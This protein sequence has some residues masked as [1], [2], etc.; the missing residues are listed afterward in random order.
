M[1]ETLY[2][3]TN[4]ASSRPQAL[5]IPYRTMMRRALPDRIESETDLDLLMTEPSDGLV[6]LFSRMSGTLAILGIGGK[7]GHTLGRQARRAIDAAGAKVRVVGVSRFSDASQREKIEESGV[8]T[9]SCDL[10]DRDAVAKL[11]DFD[12]IVFMAG[13]KFGTQGAESLTWAMNTMVPANVV[14]RYREAP[15]VAFSTGC[16]YPFVDLASGGSRESDPVGPVGEYAVS[17]LG[18]ERV[19]E[20]ASRV[21]GTKI[22]LVRL[23]YAIDL[24]YGVLHDIATTIRD[25]R[26]V[27]L[28]VPAFNAIWQGDA[29][30]E[31]LRC[32]SCCES[33]AAI[34]N[35]TGPET[36]ST[37]A[38]AEALAAG[39]GI[40][41]RFTGEAASTALL[42]NSTKALA[43]FGYPGVPM[44]KMIE[45]TA[46]WVSRSLRSLGKPTHFETKDGE[47]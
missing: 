33:P 38:T 47:F 19:F 23:N 30:D 20:Y 35:I 15:I 4:A 41:C 2:P 3:A 31:I 37:R 34:M 22:C 43:R 18:R 11:P 46:D 6:D 21:R 44:G 17:C 45:W 39:L 13:R 16:V 25:G 29:S 1:P 8:S 40:E 9:I 42:A 27:D 26:P 10:L 5:V 32:L 12:H 14:E 7:M 24:R 36:C 28:S